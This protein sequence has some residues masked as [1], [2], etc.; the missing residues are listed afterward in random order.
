MPLGVSTDSRIDTT[1]PRRGIKPWRR[2]LKRRTLLQAAMAT[3][4]LSWLLSAGLV[5]RRLLAAWPADAFHAEKL[6]DA[7]RL[8]FGDRVME[9]SDQIMIEA[10]D[11]AE[12][13]RTV[14]V[15]VRIQLPAVTA[16]TLLSS[17]NPFPLLARAKF[18]PDVEPRL[19]LRFKLGAT[20]KLIA[21]AEADGKL[22]Q[23]TRPVKVTSGG[24]GG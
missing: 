3:A 23:A 8:L 1:S 22:Y 13:G 6:A 10:P 20:G 12:N 7:Q 21:I 16:V 14:P 18:T 15:S 19:S 11:I 4:P 5:P 24:C 9:D 2:R 17:S